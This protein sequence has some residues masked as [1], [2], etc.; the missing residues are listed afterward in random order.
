LGKINEVQRAVRGLP[1]ENKRSLIRNVEASNR[2]RKFR[3]GPECRHPRE[4]AVRLEETPA[5][6]AEQHS[7]PR[8]EGGVDLGM[9]YQ[10]DTGS[11]AGGSSPKRLKERVFQ[12]EKRGGNGESTAASWGRGVN[13][14]LLR[15]G[16]FSTPPRSSVEPSTTYYREIDAAPG[17]KF[18]ECAKGTEQASY[19]S[20]AEIGNTVSWKRE[21]GGGSRKPIMRSQGG[22][23][24]SNLVTEESLEERDRWWQFKKLRKTALEKVSL[25]VSW[26][27][28][29]KKKLTVLAK[30]GKNRTDSTIPKRA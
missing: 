13:L 20:R 30:R 26:K 29:Q 6:T 21:R 24:P 17:S 27:N 7:I 16:W 11:V 15:P 2:S 14:T 28:T 8:V 19:C 5:Q 23:K 4:Q 10:D 25:F 22:S 12:Q 18:P 9:G 3:G 1:K